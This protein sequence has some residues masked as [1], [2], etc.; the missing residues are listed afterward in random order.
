MPVLAGIAGA[1]NLILNVDFSLG[2]TD[3]SSGY[4]AVAANG[5]S[6]NPAITV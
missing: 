6:L 5:T 4:T 2:N 3:F 1:D